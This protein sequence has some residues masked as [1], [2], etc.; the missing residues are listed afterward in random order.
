MNN[1]DTL[2]LQAYREAFQ[3]VLYLTI[4]IFILL[5]IFVIMLIKQ[6][7]NL[8]RLH[9]ERRNKRMIR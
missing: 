8:R 4:A 2:S 5:L 9:R 6:R 3:P 1:T 7:K